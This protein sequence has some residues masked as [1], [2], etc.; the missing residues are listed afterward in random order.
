M[1]IER[2]KETY[3][4]PFQDIYSSKAGGKK[5]REAILWI[6]VQETK[7]LLMKTGLISLIQIGNR[8]LRT[9]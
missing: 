1:L 6:Q 7:K 2:F 4:P 8:E 3:A 9:V 5:G